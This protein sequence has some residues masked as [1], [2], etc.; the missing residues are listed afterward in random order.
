MTKFLI[1]LLL[2]VAVQI[3]IS[4]QE[5]VNWL[6]WEEALELNKT[7]R[8]KIIVDVGTSWCTWCKKMDARTYKRENIAK[9][10]NENFYAVRF[11]AETKEEI[12]FNNKLYSYVSSFGKK[13]YHEL[14]E[15][16]MNGRMSYP[17]TVF[18]D[19][20]LEVIQ[21]IPGF[22]GPSTFKMIMAY[23]YGDHYMKTPWHKFEQEYK[24]NPDPSLGPSNFQPSVQPVRNH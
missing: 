24:L 12:I 9:V 4:A 14:A 2:A 16:I 21:P 20:N 3:N 5:E 10:I 15:E 18:I 13:G 7:E 22:Q 8:R 17:T 19:E 11:D 1:T 23:F 6:T